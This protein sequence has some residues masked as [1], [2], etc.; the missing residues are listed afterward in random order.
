MSKKPNVR[1]VIMDELRHIKA[2]GKSAAVL[3][4]AGV[5]SHSVLFACLELKIPVTAYSFT[6]EDRESR[7]FTYARRSADVLKVPFQPI[8]LSK[9]LRQLQ[10]FCLYARS[11]G[12]KSKTDYECS[13]P[14]FVAF[15]KIADDGHH[16]V[17]TAVAADSHF[18][19]SKKANMHY[20]DKVDV[21]RRIVFSK[22]NTGQ[23]L[24]LRSEAARLG[25]EYLTPYDTTRMCSELHGYSWDEL[26]KPKQKQ[27]IRSAFEDYFAKCKTTVHT[28][29]QLGDSGIADHF[30]ILLNSPWNK[31]G[32]KSVKGIYNRLLTG[33]INKELL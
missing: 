4:S 21:Y 30:N 11:V 25:L 12:A 24:L 1:A 16:F 10:R 26:N 33:E 32:Y 23:K 19:L 22:P 29:L 17:L 8:K 20:K 28:N 18:A 31:W 27:P 13:W 9:E 2:S 7:D 6:L 5:D 3:L 14:M 15:R